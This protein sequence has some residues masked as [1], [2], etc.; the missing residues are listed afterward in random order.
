M[1]KFFALLKVQALSFFGI[2]K[3]LSKKEGKKKGIL[4]TIGVMLF[5]AV[6][7]VAIVV[8]Y[9]KIFA[10]SFALS[11]N[12]KEYLSTMFALASLVCLI[13]SFYSAGSNLY[14]AEDYELLCSMP[15]KSHVIVLSKLSFSY[16]ADLLFALL[17]MAVSLIVGA[18]SF[19]ALTLNQ[20]IKVIIMTFALPFYP[21][22][23]SIVLGL[24]VGLISS[25]FKRKQAVQAILYVVFFIAFYAIS[26][27]TEGDSLQ[28]GT[29]K[30]MFPLFAWVYGG[31]SSV[32][33]V[34]LFV[35]VGLIAVCLI[36]AFVCITYHKVSTILRSVKKSKN[37]TLKSYSQK[38]QFGVL[39][40]KELK[41]LFSSPV[42]AMNT[43][44]GTVFAIVGTIIF[45]II[46][47][48]SHLFALAP[49]FAIIL[50]SLFALMFSMSPTTAVSI[51]VEGKS[52]YL[53]KTSPI[54]TNKLLNAKLF[55]NLIVAVVPA[56]ICSV[57]FSFVLTEAPAIFVVF[58]IINPVLYA[59]LGGSLGL[60][61]NLLFPYMN[62]DNITKAVKQSASVF[63]T[64]LC[65]FA[66]AGGTFAFLYFVQ[67]T[68]QLKMGIVCLLLVVANAVV[69]YLIMKKGENLISKK[70]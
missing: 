13:F 2:N 46:I 32:K 9:A 18:Q 67:W 4:S 29:I 10:E 61:F 64:I 69:Y 19:G 5:F 52:F 57:A 24:L 70:T 26:F 50:Q 60:M 58:S 41:T 3:V 8:I 40:K 45:V 56:L 33:Y 36:L 23:V 48:D 35:G 20:T 54:S 11:G 51:S 55:V 15:I 30:Q 68:M 21:I 39:V 25:R 49:F 17:I 42:Y 66:L 47:I 27:S 14:G 59:L 43:L 53:L 22:F 7:V 12:I 37:F 16:L 6:L 62:W 28:T 38:G 44:L 63:F 31:I 34:L 1:S 65:A